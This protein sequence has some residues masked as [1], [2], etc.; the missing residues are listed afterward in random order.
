MY[1]ETILT[2]APQFRHTYLPYI[3]AMGYTKFKIVRQKVFAPNACRGMAEG[4]HVNAANSMFNGKGYAFEKSRRVTGC[5]SG[6]FGEDADDFASLGRETEGCAIGGGV[7]VKWRGLA[8]GG[9]SRSNA[10]MDQQRA[11]SE[12]YESA[13]LSPLVIFTLSKG[14]SSDATAEGKAYALG[15]SSNSSP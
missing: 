1:T 15:P 5:G 4:D 6:P 9:K 8:G 14:C 12:D 11:C 3:L 7:G 10:H 2:V 13:E